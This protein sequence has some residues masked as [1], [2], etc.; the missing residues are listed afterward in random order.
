M[1]CEGGVCLELVEALG[2][3]YLDCCLVS[4]VVYEDIVVSVSGFQSFVGLV[5]SL[6]VGGGYF[7]A[8]FKGW[9]TCVRS[10]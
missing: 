7:A 8:N 9:R 3:L 10:A 2:G 6:Q 1:V 4:A 5:G